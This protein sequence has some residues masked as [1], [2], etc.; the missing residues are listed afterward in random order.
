MECTVWWWHCQ[1]ELSAVHLLLYSD[2][3]WGLVDFVWTYMVWLRGACSL[4]LVCVRI[5]L[6]AGVRGIVS[7]TRAC[8][9][10]CCL[11]GMPRLYM[12]WALS[13]LQ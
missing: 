6:A 9:C 5:D 12:W 2:D 1:V 4:E 7:V 8:G 13:L 10:G 3:G 11:E